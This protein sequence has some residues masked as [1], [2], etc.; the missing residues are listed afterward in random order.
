MEEE[1]GLNHL[2]KRVNPDFDGTAE[3]T[4][5]ASYRLR[6]L[7][8]LPLTAHV[9]RVPIQDWPPGLSLKK[10]ANLSGTPSHSLASGGAGP[11]WV[12][13]GQILAY[14]ALSSSHFSSPG[15]VSGLIA[16]AGHSG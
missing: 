8:F 13:L 12:I 5:R 1:S 10:R 16:S 14:S 3:A 6:N 7:G 9:N 4:L 2:K 11:F 15:S